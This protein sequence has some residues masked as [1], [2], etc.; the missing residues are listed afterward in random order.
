MLSIRR[1]TTST[2]TMEVI[3]MMKG[4]FHSLPRQRYPV[5]AVPIS[6]RS[7]I[8]NT[9]TRK[10][11][12]TP[13]TNNCNNLNFVSLST[14]QRTFSTTT[15]NNAATTARTTQQQPNTRVLGST[16]TLLHMFHSTT[17]TR[18]GCRVDHSYQRWMNDYYYSYNY[19]PKTQHSFFSTQPAMQSN[20]NTDDKSTTTTTSAISSPPPPSMTAT[21]TASSTSTTSSNSSSVASSTASLLRRTLGKTAVPTPPSAPPDT[22][23]LQSLKNATPKSVIRKGVDLIVSAS[24]LVVTQLL[25]LPFNI[26]YY[27]THPTE[28]KAAYINIRDTVKHEI[29]HYWVGTKLLWADTVTARKLLS[30][31]LGGSALTRRERKQLLRT[32]SDLFRLIPFS[33]FVIVPFMEFALPFALRIFP[34][35]LPSTYQDSLKAEENMKR[36]LKSRI[37]MAQFF[38]EYV[39]SPFMNTYD[40]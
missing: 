32:V 31:T 3:I 37:A 39:P 16:T 36:E 38:Q 22:N 12:H 27:M 35:M 28:T 40:C 19:Y 8:I 13:T 17:T 11:L 24:K 7:S 15:S 1:R 10:V 25:K 5:V 6:T 4:Q 14:L 23:P 9:I 18:S 30:K 33:M 2:N 26:F 29:H 34:N 21:T 20:D